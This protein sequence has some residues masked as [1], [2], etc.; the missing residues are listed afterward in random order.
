VW[1]VVVVDVDEC[2]EL[3]LEIGEGGHRGLGAQP[4]LHRELETFD[5]PAGGG[6]VGA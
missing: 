1:S 2:I 3:V 4:L 5:F 6:V